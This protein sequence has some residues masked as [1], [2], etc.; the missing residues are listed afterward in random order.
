MSQVLPTLVAVAALMLGIVVAFMAEGLMMAGGANAT[1]TTIRNIKII[2][3]TI[4]L[5]TLATSVASIILMT[6]HHPWIA[7]IVGGTPAV[8]IVLFLI[9]ALVVGG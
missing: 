3:L 5:V 7:A 8:L 9:V 2:M 6:R 1:P 4:A